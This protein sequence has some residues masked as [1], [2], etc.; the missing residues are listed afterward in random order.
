MLLQAADELQVIGLFDALRK[1][2]SNA[3]KGFAHK[4]EE[5]LEG[6]GSKQEEVAAADSPE[7][8]KEESA[9]QREEPKKETMN[10][11]KVEAAKNAKDAQH[12]VELGIA[13]KIK[14]RFIGSVTLNEKEVD[15]FVDA[16]GK[17]MLESDVSYDTAAYFEQM[18]KNEVS[19]RK[20]SSNGIEEEMLG[21]VREALEKTLSETK[22]IDLLQFSKER[23]SQGMK[24]VKILFLGPNGTGKTT[25]IAKLA[26]MFKSSG[27][28]CVMAASDTFR[29]AA[30]EQT[31]FHA[32]KIGVPVIKSTYGADPASIA[33]DAIAYAKAHG[34]DIVLIDSA[35][36]Q[37]TNKSLLKEMEK[38]VRVAK[39]DITLYVGESI[40]GNAIAKQI[41]E[42]S[43]TIKID[44]I[45]LTKLDC[46][47][48]GGG[49]VSISHLT[50]IPIL[51]FGTGESYDALVRYSPQ[52]VVDSILPEPKAG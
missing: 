21:V 43:K 6:S 24:P 36:R 8:K 3:I 10:G 5:E 15:N 52:F 22:G 13:T 35:G 49:A 50:G 1:K 2:L 39:P 30:I 18:L 27:I 4:E 41:M 42:F 29:A 37:D 23:V 16:I 32:N 12:V 33:F 11:K 47:A 28:A 14:S 19:G 46:D 45:I 44:G 34:I 20:F 25:T 9:L 40:S 31:E 38:I 26:Y 51:Y 48:K 17:S 7:S